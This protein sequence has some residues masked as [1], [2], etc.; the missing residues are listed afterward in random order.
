M[1]RFSIPTPF[2]I[3]P[4]NCYILETESPT[5]ID[6]GP[7]TADAFDTLASSIRQSGYEVTDIEQVLVTHPHIDHYGLAHRLSEAAEARVIAHEDA[8]QILR[9]PHEFFEHRQAYHQELLTMAGVPSDRVSTTLDN[10]ESSVQYGEA[11]QVSDE[12]GDGDIIDIGIELVAVSTPGHSPGS[13]SYLAAAADAMFTGDHVLA[14]TTPNPFITLVPGTQSQR[15]RSLPT[16]IE[17]LEKVLEIDTQI[18]YGG[19]GAPMADLHSRVRDIIEHHEQRK[20]HIATILSERQPATVYE[21]LQ[22][23]FPDLSPIGLFTGVSE[24]IGHLDLLKEENRIGLREMDGPK[25][26]TLK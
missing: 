24:V 16:Y 6:P 10:L 15:T 20:E 2:D 1:K 13:I 4:V 11:V 21:I 14:N 26:Y 19:H 5:I 7:A 25:R 23:I 8:A 22:V 3:G 9:D 17:S 18:G 12:L